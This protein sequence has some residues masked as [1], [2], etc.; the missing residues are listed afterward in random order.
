MCCG[1]NAGIPYPALRFFLIKKI[2]KWDTIE[3]LVIC[4]TIEI[5]SVSLVQVH[6]VIPGR[7]EVN[8]VQHLIQEHQEIKDLFSQFEEAGERAY[9]KKQTIAEKVI[10]EIT[11]HAQEEEQI[12]YPAVLAKAEKETKMLVLEGIEEHR[13]ADFMM[14]RLRTTPSEDETFDAKF[15]ALTESIKHHLQEEER[16]LFPESR[17]ILKDDLDRLGA[18]MEALEKQLGM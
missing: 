11:S 14:E 7:L 9:K 17:K 15:K 18:E 13:I 4:V 2:W 12:F 10:K 16:H 5:Y 8:A 1:R 3:S 6:K